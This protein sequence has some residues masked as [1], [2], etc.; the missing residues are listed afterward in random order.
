MKNCMSR[1]DLLAL[2]MLAA[3]PAGLVSEIARA[4]SDSGSNAMRTLDRFIAGYCAA[5]NAPGL[6]LGMA[7][8]SWSNSTT[9]FG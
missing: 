8:K 2:G 9:L 4:A 5:M 1:R 3:I 7:T 6:T